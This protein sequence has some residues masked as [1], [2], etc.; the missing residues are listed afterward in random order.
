MDRRRFMQTGTA[1]IVGSALLGSAGSA[2]A[3]EKPD[4]AFE[5]AHYSNYTNATRSAGDM[6]W[7]V[8]HTIEGS[9]SSG[10]SWFKNPNANVSSHFVVDEYGEIT[11]M[12][13]LQDVAWTQGNGP[14]NNTGI[15]IEMSGYA[16]S[17]D[18]TEAKYDAVAELC[19]WLCDAYDIPANHPTYDI[20]PCSAW[21]G[22]GG[23]IGHDQ[24]P[25]QYDCNQVTGGKVDPGATWNWNYLM[26]KMD[27]GT[28]SG[29]AFA[30]GDAVATTATANARTDPTVADNVVHTNPAGVRGVVKN[31]PQQADGYTWYE[32]A[33]ENG[34]VGWTV[35]QYHG[36][37]S[38]TFLHDQRVA[39]TADLNVHD[40]HYLSAPNVWTAPEGSAGYVRAGPQP[41]DGYTW[42][43]VAFNS[44]LTGWCVAE[45]LEGS[46]VE[47]HGV[48]HSEDDGGDG[49]GGGGGD[50]DGGDG[51]PA[52]ADGDLVHSTTTLNTRTQPGTGAEVV[53]AISGE[54][55]AEVVNGPVDADGY[56]W[57]G[58]H[59]QDANVWGWSVE[60]YLEAGAG[61]GGATGFEWPCSGEVTSNYYSSRSY[62]YHR[63]IDVAAPT[64]ARLGA[65]AAGTVTNTAYS[66][67]AG[68]YVVVEHDDGYQTEYMHCSEFAAS[69]GDRV[70]RGETIAYVG[71][72][73]HSTGPHLH[74]EFKRNGEALRIPVD[75]GDYVTKG[76]AYDF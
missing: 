54:A 31:G 32:V 21:S 5:P 6:R 64:G 72:T 10:I 34:I 43:Q 38:T 29:S 19:A 47:G 74:F 55:T 2:A 23:L 26:G 40:D 12:V 30:P 60:Q 7:I 15:S 39:T 17:T 71:S 59:W 73:G 63:A 11:Q 69:E 20:A 75:V 56:T 16:N 66:S 48:G 51:S 70:Q 35:E 24:V 3:A 46:P 37:A 9:A 22:Q 67:G 52:F 28:G 53:D 25:S 68:Y 61:S 13:E 62:G 27:G 76:S 45:Y 65:A 36:D 44:G 18:F 1:A 42:W 58:L 33:Y 41:A 8:V 49:G 50:G 57:W 4:M 14:Y